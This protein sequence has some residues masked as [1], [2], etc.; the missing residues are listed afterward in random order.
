MNEPLPIVKNDVF[1]DNISDYEPPE[2]EYKT[3]D[4]DAALTPLK[5]TKS[6]HFPKDSRL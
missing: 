3:P 6:K 2:I 4:N 5:Y 1:I